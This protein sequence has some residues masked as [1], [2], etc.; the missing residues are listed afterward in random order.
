MVTGERNTFTGLI[1]RTELIVII[2]KI[3]R[4]LL[5]VLP[6]SE[7]FLNLTHH[8][9]LRPPS[10]EQQAEVLRWKATDV[11]LLGTWMDLTP[12]VNTSIMTVHTRFSLHRT[13]NI[14]R[15]LGLRHLVVV[16]DDFKVA[17]IITRKDLMG[18]AIEE[19]L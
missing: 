2:S 13:Y 11:N 17:G 8:D 6:G 5:G 19:K 9:F 10:E 7:L 4:S 14:F 12:F 15:R 3:R 18:F 1:T 16:D